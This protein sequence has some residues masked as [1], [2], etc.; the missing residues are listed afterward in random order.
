MAKRLRHYLARG[1]KKYIDKSLLEEYNRLAKEKSELRRRFNSE[2]KELEGIITLVDDVPAE[3]EEQVETTSRDYE[4]PIK[5]Y[6]ELTPEEKQKRTRR[7]TSK[8]I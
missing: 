3:T 1:E 5:S 4:L 8:N 2:Y 6:E 7:E